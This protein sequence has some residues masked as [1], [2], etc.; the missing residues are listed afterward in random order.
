MGLNKGTLR[1]EEMVYHL[2]QKRVKDLN[3][4]LYCLM[5]E[6][7]GVLDDEEI[8]TAARIEGFLKPDFSI[9]YKG[10]TRYISMKSGSSKIVHSEGIKSFVLFLRS[11]G[12]SKRTQQTILLFQYG[13]K[14]MDGSG[15]ERMNYDELRHWLHDRVIEANKELNSRDIIIAAVERF[16]VLGTKEDAI[17]I[18]ALYHGDYRFGTVAT[19]AQIRKH[20]Q[21]GNWAFLQ[22][23]HIG[24]FLF[25]PHARYIGKTVKDES[26]RQIVEV[27][28]L[29]LH[30]EI[31]FMA[32]RYGH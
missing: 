29:D 12:V 18:D 2:N 11:L 30:D 8:I 32:R 21:R 13:D 20:A 19:I 9:T 15:K 28:W 7:Y 25:R 24:P 17:P 16:V 27:S 3:Q 6:L 23:L 26:K 4:N 31:D 1:E 22:N 14:T 5:Q 10:E